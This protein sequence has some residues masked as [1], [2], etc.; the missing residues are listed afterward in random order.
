MENVKGLSTGTE[1]AMLVGWVGFVLGG[2]L[3]ATI[4]EENKR[5]YKNASI[6]KPENISENHLPNAAE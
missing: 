5:R 4:E 1:A 2:V 3:C 6:S